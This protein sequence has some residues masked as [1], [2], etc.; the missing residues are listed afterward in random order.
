MFLFAFIQGLVG[1]DG[2]EGIPG[3]PGGKVG[4]SANFNDIVSMSQ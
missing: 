2:R 4:Y 1:P 3:M